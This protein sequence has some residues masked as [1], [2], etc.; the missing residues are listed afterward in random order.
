MVALNKACISILSDVYYNFTAPGTYVCSRT[1]SETGVVREGKQPNLAPVDLKVLLKGI[2]SFFAR[3]KSVAGLNCVYCMVFL[4]L[5]KR[6]SSIGVLAGDGKLVYGFLNS[7]WFS[8][9]SHFV[10]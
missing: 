10:R 7:Y 3:P 4:R 2:M 1:N 6:K 8:V 5:L 9:F